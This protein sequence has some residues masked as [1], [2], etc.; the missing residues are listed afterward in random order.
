MF[1]LKQ[2]FRNT[3]HVYTVYVVQTSFRALA[4]TSLFFLSLFWWWW[5]RWLW[6]GVVSK[7]RFVFAHSFVHHSH[8]HFVRIV[9]AFYQG[10]SSHLVTTDLVNVRWWR[11]SHHLPQSRDGG[12][13]TSHTSGWALSADWLLS[14]KSNSRY[15]WQVFTLSKHTGCYLKGATLDIHRR[16]SPSAITLAVI[17]KEQLWIYMAG[18][19]LQQPQ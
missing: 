16:S 1:I 9:L 17:W 3:S 6:G 14:G 13:K 12:C 4:V 18:L 7:F 8:V 5:W 19:H 10:N 11:P 2:S 15:T